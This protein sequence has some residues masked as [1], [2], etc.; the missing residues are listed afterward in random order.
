[1]ASSRSLRPVSGVRSWCEA[2]ATKSRWA[3][4][5]RRQGLGH[6]VEGARERVELARSAPG[7]SRVEVAL[8]EPV[9]RRDQAADRPRDGSRQEPGE[10]EA[11]E[12][13]RQADQREA[14]PAP[15]D[16]RID[17]RRRGRHSHRSHHLCLVD[18]GDGHEQQLLS[19]GLAEAAPRID[20]SAEGGQELRP[21][22]G[23]IDRA[24]VR[25]TGGVGEEPSA[26]IDDQD[27]L[28]TGPRKG[29]V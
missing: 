1:M 11:R 22:T 3:A 12:D 25:P 8:T 21:P 24:D 29:A 28:A 20:A 17:S 6:P 27:P 10:R 7:G 15:A 4:T 26:P 23:C 13:D 9:G 2:F 5:F 18:H 16:A 19:E 14:E